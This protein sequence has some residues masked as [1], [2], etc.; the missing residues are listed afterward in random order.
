MNLIIQQEIAPLNREERF[1]KVQEISELFT[2]GDYNPLD[3]Y[4]IFKSWIKVIE[5]TIE[6]QSVKNAIDNEL[7]KEG[8]TFNKFDCKITQVITKKYDYL[9]SCDSEIEQLYADIASIKERI[10]VRETFLKSI[11]DAGIVSAETGE[12][13]RR[14]S[15]LESESIRVTL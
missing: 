15:Y 7:S 14:P 8:K 10:K 4:L 12:L 2:N 3:L 9:T 1:Q 11:P 5:A 13:I 6:N